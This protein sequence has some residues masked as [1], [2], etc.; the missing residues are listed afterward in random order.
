MK[1]YSSELTAF[2]YIICFTLGLVGYLQ[3]NEFDF[4]SSC[5]NSLRLFILEFDGSVDNIPFLLNLSRFLS[6]IILASSIFLALKEYFNIAMLNFKIRHLS[7]H[8]IVFCN[9]ESD[10]NFIH[11]SSNTLLVTNI[12]CDGLLLASENVNDI[13]K[14]NI[15]KAEKVILLHDDRT[16][17]SY[18]RE[19]KKRF[20]NLENITL[21]IKLEDNENVRMFNRFKLNTNFKK[22]LLINPRQLFSREVF[23]KNPVL[24][25]VHHNNKIPHAII[26][27]EYENIKWLIFEIANISHYPSLQN[28][29]ITLIGYE[30]DKQKKN[31][32][33]EFPNINEVIDFSTICKSST[34]ISNEDFSSLDITAIYISEKTLEESQTTASHYKR[35]FHSNKTNSINTSVINFGFGSIDDIYETSEFNSE[36]NIKYFDYKILEELNIIEHLDKY[37]FI[38][39]SIHDYYKDLYGGEDWELLPESMKTSNRY[40]AYHTNIKLGYLGYIADISSKSDKLRIDYSK[41]QLDVLAQ[42]E[43]RRWNA[44]RLLNG[45]VYGKIRNDDL[46]IHPDLVP[47][48][49]LDEVAKQKDRDTVSNITN[50][51]TTLGFS[52]TR[53]HE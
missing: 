53:L 34:S 29:K 19:M 1:K 7:G 2:I 50:T 9:N 11:K 41:L 10:I 12:L 37:D 46:K 4:I 8:T 3:T 52:L 14:V 36:F 47:W 31:L 43:K 6:P 32:I 40:Q 38:A 27:G 17:L 44:E 26:S 30:S 25:Y 33:D 35:I 39:K 16:N 51:I 24:D 45:W 5:Y 21:Y 42:M 23:F 18:L 28:T 15:E 49:A 20:S 22:E 13:E 48:Q